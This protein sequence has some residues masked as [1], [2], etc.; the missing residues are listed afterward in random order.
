MTEHGRLRVRVEPWK[1]QGTEDPMFVNTAFD[2]SINDKPTKVTRFEL[3]WD[4]GN[5]LPIL[6]ISCIPGEF[7]VGRWLGEI[8]ITESQAA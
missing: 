7:E 4:A 3:T 6:K 5:A 1:K 2:L 8:E